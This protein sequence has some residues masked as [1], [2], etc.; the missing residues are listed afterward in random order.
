MVDHLADE[1]YCRIAFIAIFLLFVLHN[2]A[3][4]FFEFT[5]KG[6]D[7]F[8]GGNR[9]ETNG[10]GVKANVGNDH[11]DCALT[12]GNTK[13]AI[14]VGACTSPQTFDCDAGVVQRGLGSGILYDSPQRNVLSE[15]PPT[16]G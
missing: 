8:V 4:E 1:L 7:H 16:D 6:E 5:A 11:F 9:I 10:N 3:G 2:G 14:V 12:G 13:T 15:A